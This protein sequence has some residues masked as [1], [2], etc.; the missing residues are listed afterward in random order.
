MGL[1]SV[2]LSKDLRRFLMLQKDRPFFIWNVQIVIQKQWESGHMANESWVCINLGVF[3]LTGKHYYE[4]SCHDQG[5]CRVG[6]SSM[7]ASLDLGKHF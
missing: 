2:A 1:L 3:A 6:W 4:V 5:L 7:Q